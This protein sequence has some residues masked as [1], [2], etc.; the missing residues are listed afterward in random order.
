MASPCSKHML[1]IATAGS[2]WQATC[3]YEPVSRSWSCCLW[4][5]RFVTAVKTAIAAFKP[6][7][8][9]SQ[10]IPT[11]LSAPPLLLA[12]DASCL[13]FWKASAASTEHAQVC[14]ALVWHA[15]HALR[16]RS[17]VWMMV[18][19]DPAVICLPVL[20]PCFNSSNPATPC[21]PASSISAPLCVHHHQ[22]TPLRAQGVAED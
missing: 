4:C 14:V 9:D 16:I 18:C 11:L 21:A 1:T 22:A 20:G 3:H 12:C 13:D 17:G 15:D 5:Y 19:F 6:A 7:G 8:H 2:S 10:S